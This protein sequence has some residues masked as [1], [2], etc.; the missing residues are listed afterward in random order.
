MSADWEIKEQDLKTAVK[1]LVA[2]YKRSVYVQDKS[3]ILTVIR[4]IKKSIRI[5]TA[6]T[7]GIPVVVETSTKKRSH[8]AKLYTIADGSLVDKKE[9]LLLLGISYTTF[10]LKTKAGKTISE[11]QNDSRRGKEKVR[12]S[13]GRNHE[14]N[15]Q[16]FLDVKK[17]DEKK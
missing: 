6:D 13:P 2:V 4:H 7:P 9:L 16:I 14:W 1:M 5:V 17:K 15:K 11:L 8:A 10:L 12:H 3:D